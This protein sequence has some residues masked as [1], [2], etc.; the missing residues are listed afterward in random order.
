M[1]ARRT[2]AR[3]VAAMCVVP[4]VLFAGS[5]GVAIAAPPTVTIDHPLTGSSTN[6]QAPPIEGATDDVLDP[7]TVRIYEGASAAGTEVQTLVVPAPLEV[8][9]LEATWATAPSSNLAPGQYTAIAEQ[10]NA[11]PETGVSAEVT[12]TIDTT[13]PTVTVTAPAANATLNTSKPTFSGSAGQE[14]G[15]EPAVTVKIYAGS[16]V[17]GSPIRS[18]IA[19]S[20]AGT[21]STNALAA[22]TDGTYTAQAE[23]SDEAGNTG[24]S[25]AVTFTIDTTPPTVTITTPTTN[26]T[27]NLSKP[28]LSGGAG[29]ANGDEH[30]ITVKIYAGSTASGSPTQTDHVTPSAGNWTTGPISALANGTY[31]AQAEQSDAA[32][33]TGTSTAVTF[34]IATST[35]VVKLQI[36]GLIAR[37]TQHMTGP[38]PSFA[39]TGSTAPEDGK[40]VTVNVY[41]GETPSGIPV[42]TLEGS[43]TGSSWSAGPVA[44]LADGT[45]TA[46]ALQ[47]DSDF[48][49]LPGLSEASTFTVDATPPMV[50]LTSPVNGSLT[51]SEFESFNGTAGSAPGDQSQ[52]TVKLFAGT[53]I[54]SQSLLK[55]VTVPVKAGSWSAAF[56]GLASGTYTARAQQSDDVH[57]TGVS[58]PVTFTVKLPTPSTPTV[59]PPSPALP[60]ASFQWFPPAPHTGEPISLISTS[61]DVAGSI[62]GFAWSLTGGSTFT[63]GGPTLTTSF[64]TPGSHMVALRVTDTNGRSSVVTEPIPVTAPRPTLMRPFPVVRIAGSENAAGVKIGLLT[65]L[66]PIGATVTVSCHGHGC[67]KT[68]N[69]LATSGAS[70]NKAGTVLISFRRFQ[71]SLR[72]GAILQIKVSAPGQIGKYTRFSVRRGKLPTR[73]DMCLSATGLKPIVCPSS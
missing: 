25:T 70:K 13:L 53:S 68:Q 28:T 8:A 62:A 59:T 54:T 44:A 63:A 73:V 19:T 65:V 52:I 9:P 36:P 27:L 7:V 41:T 67:P 40:T 46:R 1:R 55:E 23:Q 14:G 4:I 38:T 71:R 58:A 37:R 72:A 5:Q 18:T 29:Q 12:F 17:S 30:S 11:E 47:N 57:N 56:G 21:W 32:G 34:T 6:D 45:Y 22:L 2:L 43:L 69:V 3:S 51:T 16:T 24:T 48:Y 39:G 50:T 49:N 20:S 33:N 31:T 66:A 60:V 35:P 64:A 61:T 15:D 10:T 26:A 42:R